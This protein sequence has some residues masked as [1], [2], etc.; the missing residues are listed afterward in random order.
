MRL[1]PS[2]FVDA[3]RDT[4]SCH[5]KAQVLEA[6]L[7]ESEHLQCNSTADFK[8]LD[9]SLARCDTCGSQ[10]DSNEVSE[11]NMRRELSFVMICLGGVAAVMTTFA[12]EP[13]QETA[14][15]ATIQALRDFQVLVGDWRG[16]GQPKRGSQQGA[17]QERANAIWELKPESRGI[18]W[19]VESGKLW[20][21]ALFGFD[22]ATQQY[23][24]HVVLLDDSAR[25]YRG[26]LDEKRLVLE[27]DPD[28][29]KDIHRVTLT[30]MNDNRV[31][32]LMEKRPEPQS[33]YTRVAEIG[34]QRDGTRLATA[35][36]S[37]PECVVTGGLG[38]IKVSYM[39]KSYYVCCTGCRDAF[40]D[41]PEGILADY[42][43]R[44]AEENTKQK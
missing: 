23:T 29:S 30:P 9:S 42:R 17:W 27:S 3:R 19:N 38:T 32:L 11:V 33:F 41:D 28:A 20:K 13:E 37:G 12:A 36:N 40:N 1:T 6:K 43:K 5:F 15:P 25:V 16:I 21:S 2:R 34:Y 44:K 31:I 24:L 26:K 7:I 39:G 35:G 4:F 22:D 8:P 14:K 18:R 10:N